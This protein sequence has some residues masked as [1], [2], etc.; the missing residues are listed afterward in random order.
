MIPRATALERQYLSVTT[1]RRTVAGETF[2]LRLVIYRST[3][4]VRISLALPGKKG[5]K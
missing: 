5:F 4:T 3:S 2:A 1:S